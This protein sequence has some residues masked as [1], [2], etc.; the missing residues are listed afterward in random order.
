M[1]AV[2]VAVVA[3]LVFVALNPTLPVGGQDVGENGAV[4]A[5]GTYVVSRTLADPLAALVSW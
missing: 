3:L 4:A 1:A 5:N 2:L